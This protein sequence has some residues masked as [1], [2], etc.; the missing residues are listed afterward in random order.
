[1]GYLIEYFKQRTAENAIEKAN[2]HAKTAQQ[3]VF[4]LK[5]GFNALLIEKDYDKAEKI[6]KNVD[7]IE[8]DAD[9]L[10]REILEDISK[11][12]L[13]PNVRMDLSHL[14]KRIDDIANC[15]NGVGR[16]IN[17]ISKEFWENCSQESIDYIIQIIDKTV[18][19]AELLDD[20]LNAL[21]KSREK[22]KDITIKINKMEHEVD[23][24]NLKLSESLQKTDFKINIFTGFLIA[25][26]LNILEAIS[27]SIEEVADY[28]L[29]LTVSKK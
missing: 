13:N 23:I 27:D 7:K 29:L 16:R 5:K 21:I 2:T 18:E 20:L 6:F 19:C 3:C 1:M 15:S 17:T 25:D 24:L 14:V 22:V 26:T 4:E 28:I 11:G 9:V 8:S 10:R 12:E